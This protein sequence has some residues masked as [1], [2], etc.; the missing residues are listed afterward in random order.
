M[1]VATLCGRRVGVL[2]RR[3]P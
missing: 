1:D 2:A 3:A